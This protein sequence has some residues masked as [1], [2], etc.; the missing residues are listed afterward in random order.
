MQARSH[1]IAST[2]APKEEVLRQTSYVFHGTLALAAA[3]W[4]SVPTFPVPVTM[5]VFAVLVVGALLGPR[6]GAITVIAWLGE[7]CLGLPVLAHGAAGI[8]PFLGPT[9]GYLA[10]FPVIAAFVGWL[11]QRGWTRS[12]VRS[13][14]LML[15]A[16][17]INLAMGATWLAAIFGWHRAFAL[18]VEPFLVGA[19]VQAFLATSAVALIQKTRVNSRRAM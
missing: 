2:V 6:L 15:A 8:L 4:V 3:S 19:A 9:A 1:A 18:G 7:A 5:Q 16:N 10:S 13:L 12:L 14:P 17:A 11:A